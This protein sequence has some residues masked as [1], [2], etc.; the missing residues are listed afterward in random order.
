VTQNNGEFEG[1]ASAGGSDS[2]ILRHLTKLTAASNPIFCYSRVKGFQTHFH[3]PLRSGGY[4]NNQ[5]AAIGT[6]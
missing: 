5:D 4:T 3:L 6:P 1:S 2:G